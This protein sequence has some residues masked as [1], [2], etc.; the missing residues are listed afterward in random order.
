MNFV[1]PTLLRLI[2]LG[3]CK[4][5]VATQS[6]PQGNVTQPPPPLPALGTTPMLACLL[7]SAAFHSNLNHVYVT[8]LASRTRYQDHMFKISSWGWTCK[9]ES[10]SG[11]LCVSVCVSMLLKCVC[12]YVSFLPF[13]FLH[14]FLY[15]LTASSKGKSLKRACYL[16]K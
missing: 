12:V 8:S 7:A 1:E 13:T 11:C 6:R 4:H 15:V 14:V 10:V 16:F 3:V 5:V 2:D 9:Q